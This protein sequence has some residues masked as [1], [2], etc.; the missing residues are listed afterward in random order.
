MMIGIF[1][2]RLQTTF[3]LRVSAILNCVNKGEMRNV[4]NTLVTEGAK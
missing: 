4:V 1:N 2:M 3:V